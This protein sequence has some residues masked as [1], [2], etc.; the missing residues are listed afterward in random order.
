MRSI[1]WSNNA[2]GQSSP[3]IKDL[4]RIITAQERARLQSFPDTFRVENNKMC[5]IKFA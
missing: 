3:A 1:V 2:K 5:L 4:N